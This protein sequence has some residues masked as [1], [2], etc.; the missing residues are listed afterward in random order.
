MNAISAIE[1]GSLERLRRIERQ[2]TQRNSPAERLGA[3]AL[4]QIERVMSICHPVEIRLSQLRDSGVHASHMFE[5]LEK[6]SD[7]QTP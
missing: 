5:V 2:A 6:D 7:S 1:R 4:A 3:E